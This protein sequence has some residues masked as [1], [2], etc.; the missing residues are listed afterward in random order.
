MQLQ[1]NGEGPWED[2]HRYLKE[3]K[4]PGAKV[5]SW[6]LWSYDMDPS[7]ATA[8]GSVKVKVRA[9]GSN[10]EVQENRIEDLYNVRGI[11]NNSNDMLHFRIKQ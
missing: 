2:A 6:T 11:L 1:F 5:F 8:D 10:G 4:R 9:I 3:D 7:K